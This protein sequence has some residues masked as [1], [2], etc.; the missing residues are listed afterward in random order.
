MTGNAGA[1][2]D[3]GR[4]PRLL[5]VAAL[6]SSLGLGRGPGCAAHYA[7][8]RT[9]KIASSRKTRRAITPTLSKSALAG[10]FQW[11]LIIQRIAGSLSRV[12]Q[13][14]CRKQKVGEG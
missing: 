11:P 5:A 10:S 14:G 2:L 3:T 6:P 4:T 8:W 13:L 7:S 9:D 12:P 1:L